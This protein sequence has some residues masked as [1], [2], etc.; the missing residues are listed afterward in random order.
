MS[1]GDNRSPGLDPAWV[2][3]VVHGR[4]TRRDV[5]K[6]VSL[7]AGSTIVG[8]SLAACSEE[9]I[10]EFF[11]KVRNRPVRRNLAD[12]SPG[13]PILTSYGT[14]I[15]AMKALPS[16]DGRSWTSQAEIHNDA[17]RHRSWL[18]FPWHR[19]YLRQFERICAEL[20]G[21]ADFALPYWDWTANPQLPP[22]FTTPGSPLHHS[23][24]TA[25]SSSTANP[26]VVG[27]SVI[28]GLYGE[29]NFLV[30]A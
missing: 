11:E 18:F 16:S 19:A 23:P 15:D 5:L 9:Q 2:R 3:G 14:A 1:G 12:L 6:L 24:R 4:A 30:F 27:A 17:C 13:D 22:A 25:T 20:S 7:L 28:D 10:D 29:P 21:K 8:S 26:A